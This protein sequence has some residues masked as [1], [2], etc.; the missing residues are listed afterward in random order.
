MTEAAQTRSPE[1]PAVPY[2]GRFSVHRWPTQGGPLNVDKPSTHAGTRKVWSD[3]LGRP[4]P[5]ASAKAGGEGARD[6]LHLVHRVTTKTS[7]LIISYIT[8][9]TGAGAVDEV[10]L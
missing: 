3:R 4:H 1:M 5:P 10:Y 8:L 2:G 7:T 9:E 6:V